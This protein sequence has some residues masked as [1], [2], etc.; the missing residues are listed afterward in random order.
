MR[1]G[2]L[3][4]IT[5][6]V[7]LAAFAQFDAGALTRGAEAPGQSFSLQD[8][9]S[10]LSG[11]PA[12]LGFVEG[13]EVD[14]L[15]NGYYG[16]G[17][18]DANA[19]YFTGGSGPLA[20]GL[21][22][23]WLNRQICPA[24]TTCPADTG[25]FSY[26]R[27]SV[28]GAL[29]LG[30][31]SLGA[32]HR[33]FTSLDLSAWDFGALARPVRWLALGAAALDAN[34]PGDDVPRRWAVSA[35][36]RPLGEKLDVATD[37][38]WTECTAAP[39]GTLCGLDHA[40]WLFTAQARAIRGLTVIGQV[41]VQDSSV[42]GLVGLQVDFAH[43]GAAYAPTFSSGTTRDSWRLR[44]STQRWPSVAVPVAYAADVDLKKALA[45]PKPGAWALVF[46]ASARDPLAETLATFRRLSRDPSV[47]AV[48]LR[49]GGLP[50]GP[51]RAEEL[52]AGIENLRASGKKVLFYLESGGDLEYSVALSADRIYAP[53]QAVLLVNGFAATALFAAAGL[54][55]LGVKAEF[56]RVGA[57]KNAP[58]LFTRSDMSGE[59]REVESSLLDDLYGRYVKRIADARHLDERKV[60][61]LL[62][63]GILKPGEAV[64]AGL[65]DG[66]VYPDQLEEEA[67]KLLGKNV[68][69]RKTGTEAPA[70]RDVRWGVRPKIGVVRVI[71]DI[72]RGEGGRDPF[73]VVHV[74]GSDAVV[75]RI[76]QLGDDPAV[77]AIVVRIDSPGGDGNA[78]DLI[79]RE[80]LWARRVKK[81]PV[82]ASRG[83]VAASGGYY[84]AAA[85]DEIFAEP[86]TITGS[87]GVFIGHF[88][89]AELLG[90]LGLNL[91]TVKRGASADLFNPNRSLTDAERRTLQRWVEAFYDEFVTR[92]AAARGLPRAEVDRVGQGRVWT[93][94][95]ALDRKLVDRLGGLEDALAEAKRRAGLSPGEEA[96]IDDEEQIGVDLADFAGATA[97][98]AV[99]LGLGPR[100]VR[101]L[102]LLGEPGTMRA[103]L[104]F[105]LEVQ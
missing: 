94:A 96:E 83:D 35:G 8:D 3:C 80:L 49:S 78:S 44:A 77:A 95:Q 13:L 29:R 67:G 54:D 20:L 100:A 98:D 65:I 46:G 19:L 11:N 31:L 93:G 38:L 52:R 45:R 72:A 103:A 51:G 53:P 5:V 70:L 21:G 15:H 41:G 64:S 24:G 18:G 92:V 32:V 33:G 76:H 50:L 34:R 91:V 14:F 73:G 1:G 55:K 102:R 2:I 48:V 104:P 87:I 99:P 47:R 7:P 86:S 85:A 4:S 39:A 71:G 10:S 90:K 30:Q 68:S 17:L 9:G 69:L 22:F 79:W 105:D 82:I 25:I 63:E 23:D 12:G 42:T 56:F 16:V 36:V 37:L 62:D 89:A 66:L 84:V 28:G 57:Y 101:A 97:L 6:A 75:R 88:D 60:K 27:T 43:V 59:Q 26:R 61:S 81:K 58:D 74:A 40:R